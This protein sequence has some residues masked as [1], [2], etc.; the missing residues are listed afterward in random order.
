M[1]RI[2]R[3]YT[4]L[5]VLLIIVSGLS[6]GTGR[7]PANRAD[8]KKSRY[9]YFEG[10]RHDLESNP[11]AAY[12]CYRRAVELNPDNAEAGYALGL[13]RLSVRTDTMFSDV[14][15]QKTLDYMR[16][17]VDL[18][19]GD[20]D[21]GL[22]YGYT[23]GQV[24][25]TGESIR[26][27]EQ[28]YAQNP[29]NS[30]VLVYLSQAYASQGKKDQAIEALDRF[31]ANEGLSPT[32]TLHK[33]SLLME[34]RDTTGAIR[35]AD[36]L[37]ADSPHE[38]PPLIL[39][40]NLYEVLQQPDSAEHYYLKA[41]TMAPEASAPKVALMEVYGDR[42][43][44]TAYDNKVYEVLL[45]EDMEREQK[46]QLLAKYLQKLVDDKQN[47]QRGDYLF[48]VLQSQYPHEPEV[49]NLA[50]RYS[51]AKN[52]YADAAEQISYAIDL[53][54]NNMDYWRQLMF[55]QVSA[56]DAPAALKTYDRAAKAITPDR[57]MK[58]YGAMLLQ[59]IKDY[60]GA[61]DRYAALIHEVDSGLPING[62]VELKKVRRDISLE[63][64][65]FLSAVYTSMGDCAYSASD[66][67]M[68]Y[69]DYDNALELNP[70]NALAANNYAYFSS[71]SGG[72]LEKA[73]KLSEQSMRGI[74]ADNPTYLD[75]YAWILYLQ[76]DKEKALEYQRK[77]VEG[78]ERTGRTESTIFDHYGDILN[79]L[80]RKEEALEYWLK[81]KELDPEN[82]EIN[83]K[84]E[85][86]E[87]SGVKVKV[88][89]D[90]KSDESE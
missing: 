58:L 27:L 38:Y 89:K 71:M 80:D 13:L 78:S 15:R 64:L 30:M 41:Q 28:V 53:D 9:Y 2:N 32:L 29:E 8:V 7:R 46:T 34:A 82:E 33:M 84:I 5:A 60:D 72:D 1:K 86:A 12:E 40:G 35:E 74:N 45:T 76:G 65:D 79:S 11:D 67:A 69:Q 55:Y 70:D 54:P 87:K 20:T 17:F 36:R 25:T 18:Y 4:I 3:I 48:S 49:L 66:T 43:D 73:R 61:R 85:D 22:F 21:E 47:T 26:V 50:A 56:G 63:D 39:K 81:A 14:E 44:S 16:R 19:P 10:L 83:R 52:N 75:T 31:E 59:E 62:K 90:E 6:A 24:D 57:S 68:A 51:A 88:E 42:G 37:I 77:A 23:V